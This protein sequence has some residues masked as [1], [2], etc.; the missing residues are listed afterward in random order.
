VVAF[1]LKLA[2]RRPKAPEAALL[3]LL[4][5]VP[6]LP[7]TEKSWPEVCALA[8]AH[9]VAPLLHAV[10][11]ELPPAAREQLAKLRSAAQAEWRWQQ[12][13]LLR[14]ASALEGTGALVIGG[15]A[16]AED[17]Y[18]A[19]ELRPVRDLELLIAPSR[20]FSTL[21]RLSRKG[22]QIEQRPEKGWLVLRLIDPRDARVVVNLRR[23]FAPPPGSGPPDASWA[24][25][26][27]KSALAV[28]ALCLRAEGSRLHPDDAILV[29]A[30][31]LAEEGLRSPLIAVV[32]LAHLFRRCDPSVVVGR[33]RKSR[34]LPQVGMA[35]LL[36][37][38]C[39][40]AAQRFG[41]VPVELTRI[42]RIHLD[43]SPEVDRAVDQFDLSAERDRGGALTQVARA[44]RLVAPRK[45]VE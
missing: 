12:S 29:H 5:G 34:V 44:L 30:L 9:R 8:E 3:G 2:E 24:E 17:F 45:G 1:A 20:T 42:P 39:V 15:A 25:P 32:D 38:R 27:V 7:G 35:L 21:E 36:L 19:P 43:V 6:L 26:E 40:A 37:E 33:A 16:Y 4:R 10:A 11:S 13:A 22:Y 41:G 18:P 14:I 31:A 28:G 23:G